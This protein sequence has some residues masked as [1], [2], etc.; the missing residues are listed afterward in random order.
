MAEREIDINLK[1][2]STETDISK[3][4]TPEVVAEYKARMAKV[5][6]RGLIVDRFHVD[7]P[8]ELHGEWHP[9]DAVEQARLETLGFTLD[10]QYAHKR[11]LHDGGDG[12]AKIGDVAFYTQP[13]W[14]HEHL[15]ERRKEAYFNTHLKKRQK[16]ESDFI[17]NQNT[18]GEA[19]NTTVASAAQNVTG[20]EIASSLTPPKQ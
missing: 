7:L 12:V 17:A 5:L 14:M 16:E 19:G 8:P 1:K 15:E 18:I 3:A 20:A 13:K 2:G 11:G 4:P 10:T 9:Y 6:E